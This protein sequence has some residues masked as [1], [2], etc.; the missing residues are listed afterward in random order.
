[1]FCL[2]S[3]ILWTVFAQISAGEY[4]LDQCII[5]NHCMWNFLEHMI[6]KQMR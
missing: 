1:M 2:P 6:V 3:S 5:S 4:F